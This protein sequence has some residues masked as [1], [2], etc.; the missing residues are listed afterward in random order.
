[1]D[2]RGTPEIAASR[3][4]GSRKADQ[5]KKNSEREKPR[6]QKP[7]DGNKAESGNRKGQDSS[8]KN[9]NNS[10]NQGGADSKQN[11]REGGCFER[12][13]RCVTK[14]RRKTCG[15]VNEK[16]E[17]PPASPKPPNSPQPPPPPAAPNPGDGCPGSRTPC[18]LENG[19][20][21]CCQV[22]EQCAVLSP[23]QLECRPPTNNRC[24][25]P[26]RTI[27]CENN[28][29]YRWCCADAEACG[30]YPGLSC[31][32]KVQQP[33]NPAP[34]P[35]APKPPVAK[36]DPAPQPPSG[37]PNP[38]PPTEP[39]QQPEPNPNPN[40]KPVDPPSIPRGQC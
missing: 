34:Q 19:K 23:T 22:G 11:T 38:Q 4:T 37:N 26:G 18:G 16:K 3:Q 28:A 7:R 2:R 15:W 21:K 25:A 31:K 13:W 1:M 24:T 14:N 27:R 40:P 17:C 33:G 35:P 8:I 10:N 30:A 39:E 9:R 12:V 29:G 32:P 5:N 36:P 20:P 6:D